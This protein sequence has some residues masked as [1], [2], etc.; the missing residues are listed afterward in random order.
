MSV[1]RVPH[2]WQRPICLSAG[3]TFLTLIVQVRI[4]TISIWE[5][6]LDR[7]ELA[8]LIRSICQT[9][10][11]GKS[12]SAEPQNL[13]SHNETDLMSLLFY[14]NINYNLVTE[15][16]QLKIKIGKMHRIWITFRIFSPDTNRLAVMYICL[17]QANGLNTFKLF[18][19]NTDAEPTWTAEIPL[20]FRFVS[21]NA[22]TQIWLLSLIS[23]T[24]CN[25]GK[26]RKRSS[27][28]PSCQASRHTSNP[29]LGQVSQV[30]P[31][32]E[33]EFAQ[34]EFKLETLITPVL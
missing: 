18:G 16:S 30:S 25:P 11:I 5:T 26:R 31:L 4:N 32:K 2:L 28:Y 34:V 8:C 21:Q 10:I 15:G 17:Y 12:F 33:M 7:R 19:T 6:V 24:C 23:R 13:N 3:A 22:S 14:N 27:K 20:N 9:L 1:Q 29:L